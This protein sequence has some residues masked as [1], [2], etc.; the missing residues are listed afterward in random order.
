M[1]KTY[2][3]LREEMLAES[4]EKHSFSNQIEDF[5]AE[6]D[7]D[8]DDAIV[9]EVV[10]ADVKELPKDAGPQDEFSQFI[11]GL[12]QN[13]DATIIISRKPDY[14][15]KFRVP[16]VAFGH[17]TTIYWSGQQPEEIY[18]DVQRNY[19]GGRYTF[20][21]RMGRSF[22]KTWE[23]TLNDPAEPSK[24]E[25]SIKEEAKAVEQERTA[26]VPSTSQTVYTAPPPAAA[27]TADPLDALFDQ[28][29]KVN[30]LK[31]ALG[32]D[33]HHTQPA[34]AAMTAEDQLKL[35]IFDRM[36]D[37]P[38]LAEKLTNYAFGIF[39]TKKEK[40]ETWVDLAKEVLKN[41][42]EAKQIFGALVSV[43]QP[44]L[45]SRSA[46]PAAAPITRPQMPS[47]S[48]IAKIGEQIHTPPPAAP[49]APAEPMPEPV[50]SRPPS[51]IKKVEW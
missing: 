19:G 31:E 11:S 14:N 28:L 38:E 9:G 37:R 23:I 5:D 13:S 41:P 42:G 12:P 22:G 10:D 29:D 40:S 15:L 51:V 20:Q 17:T 7:V 24:L 45:F 33:D 48:G 34:A 18:A 35:R 50:I 1:N 3:E 49:P 36:A 4:G 44:L 27:P 2:E 32:V 16:C 47:G 30:K 39:E 8:D 43:V 46:S 6:P 21:I 26:D 25:R